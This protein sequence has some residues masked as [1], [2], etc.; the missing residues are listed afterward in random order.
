MLKRLLD[1]KNRILASPVFLARFFFVMIATGMMALIAWE[2]K[3]APLLF[4]IIGFVGALGFVVIEVSTK[5]ISARKIVIA[6]V[7]VLCGIFF[8]EQ[9]Y[10]T[11]HKLTGLFLQ[12][13]DI[14]RV[15]SVS[16]TAIPEITIS[17]ETSRLICH[18]MFGY[19]GLVLALRHADWLHIGN[20]KFYLAS[21]GDRPKVLDSS[22]IVDGR[23]M[24]II[25]LRLFNGP[26]LIPNFVLAEIQTL[27]DSADPTRRARGRRGLD[28]LDKLRAG[29]KS[30][31]TIETDY[32]GI[33][34]V[35]Q[36]LVQLCREIN[37]ELVTNDF[38]LQK[39]A[40]VQQVQTINLNEMAEA[41][42]PSAYI[43]EVCQIKIVKP[44][45]EPGQGVGYFEDGSMVVVDHASE[46]VGR[47]IEVVVVSILQNPSGRLIFARVNDEEP[48]GQA[49]A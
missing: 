39:I 10:P 32:P 12:F 3:Q 6:A 14:S 9:F 8:G 42:R 37:A 19:F 48:R 36:K 2:S 21:P 16:K 11:F 28:V 41:L 40:Q 49:R 15:R 44:G 31:D 18:V 47:E 26:I 46:L 34:Q 1:S 23:I 5:T 27:A 35:D 29:C 22:V 13:I 30:L 20:L 17:S 7:G 24:D 33:R 38:N 43:G 45:R 4:S 25:A